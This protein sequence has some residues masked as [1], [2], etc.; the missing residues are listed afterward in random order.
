MKSLKK[1]IS[2]F[3]A[4]VMILPLIPV[5]ELP[6]S[7]AATSGTTGAC[8]WILEGTVLTISGN[9]KMADYSARTAPWF[10]GSGN[11]TISIT[12][13]VIEPGVTHI[14]NYAFFGCDVAP[15]VVI[16]DSVTTIGTGAFYNCYQLNNVV[17]P[18]DVTSLG[19]KEPFRG[20]KGLTK[21]TFLGNKI[22]SIP[23]RCFRECTAL[24][25]IELPNSVKTIVNEAFY[26]AN[27]LK[28]VWFNG[29]TAEDVSKITVEANNT[30]YVN[31]TKHCAS[32]AHD[33][34]CN[35]EACNAT[36]TV[37]EHEYTDA[38]DAVCNLVSCSFERV[39]PHVYNNGCV[40]NACSA[41]GAERIAPGHT[42]D[43]ECDVLCDVCGSAIESTADHVYGGGEHDV[44]CDNCGFVNA[45]AYGT[46]GACG[47]VLYGTKLVIY[48]NGAMANYS[49]S[50]SAPWKADYA[51]KITEIVIESGVTNIGV[52]AF[53]GLSY[54]TKI[55]IPNTV[56]T[57]GN[58]AFHSC[59]KLKDISI[60]NS[61]TAINTGAF[62]GCSSITELVIPAS[63]TTNVGKDTFRLCSSLTSITFLNEIESIG[64]MAF[65]QC[66]AL[67]KI[68]LP[69]GVSSIG[70]MAFYNCPKLT[71]I[72]FN[73]SKDITIS[74][75]SFQ[76]C[77]SIT[78]VWFNGV[79]SAS[80]VTITTTSGND[81]NTTF[82]SAAKH[83]ASHAHDATCNIEGCDATRVVPEHEYTDA[84]DASCNV[85]GDVRVA[86]H[87]YN[88]GC[89]DDACSVC[90]ETRTPTEHAYD[91]DFDT[92]CNN[93]GT[94]RELPYDACGTTGACIW[95]LKDGVLTISGNGAM[96]NYGSGD[97]SRSPW[98]DIRTSITKVVVADGV[99]KIGN[100]AFYSC[101]SLTQVSISN[102]VTEIGN[103]AFFNCQNLPQITIPNS[104]V[105]LAAGA[106]YQCYA[107][108]NV[109]IPASVTGVIGK[110]TFRACKALENITF[111]S[112]NI[113]TIG[114]MAFRDCTSLKSIEL[115]QSVTSLGAQTFQN[116][117][118]LMEISLP[119]GL[120]SVADNAFYACN[121]FT[122]YYG[123]RVS[124]RNKITVSATGNAP[125]QNATWVYLP[126]EQEHVYDNACDTICNEC[127]AVRVAP[128]VY[129]DNC[130]VECNAC[131]HIRDI[132]HDYSV[133]D[134]NDTEHWMKC[135][136]CGV[137]NEV[138]REAHGYANACDPTCD[139]CGYIR[140]VGDHVFTNCLDTDCNECGATREALQHQY[141]HPCLGIKCTACGEERVAPGHTTDGTCADTDCEICGETLEAGSHEYADCEATVCGKCG[142]TREAPGHQYSNNCDAGCNFCPAT[143]VPADHVYAN[144]CDAD[145]NECGAT[146][147]P[148]DHVYDNAC[149]ADCNEC[150]AIRT[151][152]DH[153]YANN[154]DADCNECGATRTPA[155]HVYDNAID[156]TCNEC[157]ASRE[158][159]YVAYGTTGECIWYLK[160][161]IF[162]V[163]GNGAMADYSARSAPWYDYR[164]DMTKLVIESGVTKIGNHS[165]FACAITEVV[166]SESVTVIGNGAFYN[167]SLLTEIVIPKNVTSIGT[168]DT[169]RGCSKLTKITFLTE[170]LSLIPYYGFRD[171][172]ALVTIELPEGVDTIDQYAFQNCTALEEI[173][174]PSTLATVAGNAFYGCAKITK[175]HYNGRVSDRNKIAIT[176][177]NNGYLLNA[178]WVYLPCEQEQHV[179]DNLIDT[180]C[181]ECGT[182]RELLYDACGTTGACIWYLKDGVLTISGNGAMADYN[183]NNLPWGKEITEVYI[184]PGVTTIGKYAFYECEKLTSVSIA[185]TVTTINSEVF[186]YC[187]SLESITIPDSVTVM[188]DRIFRDCHNLKEV[189]LSKNIQV[190]DQL[191]FRNCV[192]LKQLVIPEGVKEIG[193]SAFYLAGI[194]KVVLPASLQIVKE[195]AFFATPNLASVIFLSS[196]VTIE[197]QAFRKCPNLTTVYFNGMDEK[198]EFTFAEDVF[199]GETEVQNFVT[200]NE[201][202]ILVGEMDTDEQ[203]CA[204]A[205]G[206]KF[207]PIL[208]FTNRNLTL[209]SDLNINFAIDQNHIDFAKEIEGFEELY[210]IFTVGGRE[211][212]VKYHFADNSY[213]L[214]T[215]MNLAPHMMGD[216]ITATL[217][218]VADGKVYE[219]ATVETTILSY[220]Q[221]VLN[222]EESSDELKTLMADLVIYGSK[223]QIYVNPDISD[224]EL[225]ENKLV[226]DGDWRAYATKTT[227]EAMSVSNAKFATVEEPKAKWTGAAL[228]LNDSVAIQLRF[229]LLEEV[230]GL[231]A[232][233]R[234]KDGNFLAKLK[235]VKTNNAGDTYLL[236]DGLNA[237]EMSKEVFVTFYDAEGT[238]ISNTLRYSVESYVATVHKY[239]GAA[240]LVALIDAMFKYGCS[241][242]AFANPNS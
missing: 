182:I 108:N 153:V 98:Y 87:V 221:A 91:N 142:E 46:T 69:K 65:R 23:Q 37:P 51:G 92:D 218:V 149:D 95:Y 147:V 122:V 233:V 169:F 120:T 105:T 205:A 180:S 97:D 231:N 123:G 223:A 119:V 21:I 116:C 175:V 127:E 75:D 177:A 10:S 168:R 62:Y 61:I 40:D 43:S 197:K 80:E 227:P 7:A 83:Y 132:T 234:D 228:Y 29:L 220:C 102:S 213:Y 187:K 155:D 34:T 176:A 198:S 71:T 189:T 113:S 202:L 107:L 112:E 214:F 48:G 25:S 8:T 170:S 22:E 152:A 201:N 96:G 128:H 239:G 165:F 94:I 45:T 173:S 159:P 89:V 109:V 17:I 111:L 82:N 101:T 171:C 144:N 50:T 16:P 72:T 216:K 134:H 103:Y 196:N 143:R 141:E 212:K 138:T 121:G 66:S 194:E 100:Y 59:A 179:Y 139:E 226:T 11:N 70:V 240:E 81:Y 19:A 209:E 230:E 164:N 110:D 115:P 148:A 58:Y 238:A 32:H 104:V 154:C 76:T 183:G 195:T 68:D 53:H 208:K 38:C 219:G 6:V 52:Y 117:T 211:V 217:Y 204:T 9:G 150:G 44:V 31:A 20:C 12:K 28:H 18:A 26:K 93:C 33:A 85:C 47:W 190:I 131:G 199:A 162:T 55:T 3:L 125:L 235:E 124:D 24:E 136:V 42:K 193:I 236:F 39:A 78:D 186:G 14:G 137:P 145:C 192:A 126:C 203:L 4:L 1:I 181:N 160:D 191:T 41:C 27:A 118:S 130:D 206:I 106:F 84:C 77:A 15:E 129:D 73:D 225:V 57:I 156:T 158:L 54:V 60:P 36:R 90:G 35:D 88:N 167:C 13:I 64:E 174:L 178:T 74:P 157:G 210:A 242:Y 241:A 56:E 222:H 200:E 79:D 161:G 229:T 207:V 114:N 185:D 172:P 67:T 63:V 146:R 5:L 163:S 86:P 166:I 133:Q 184:L 237:G 30:P 135:S 215:L 140:E 188:K 232:V 151:P 224:N 99:T 2:V 49:G